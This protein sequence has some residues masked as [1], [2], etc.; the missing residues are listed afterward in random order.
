MSRHGDHDRAP[1]AHRTCPLR[2]ATCGLTLTLS[3]DRVTGIRGDPDDVFSR[4]FICPKGAVLGQLH[5]DP[6]RVRTPLIRDGDH[7]RPASWDEAFEL[8]DARLSPILAA[9]RNAVAVYLGNPNVHNLSGMSHVRPLL[10][11]GANPLASTAA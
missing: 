7:H 5:D 6:D 4:G 9:D 10:M 1:H 11:L 8:I 2:E 3:G